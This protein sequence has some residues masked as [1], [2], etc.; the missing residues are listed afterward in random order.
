MQDQLRLFVAAQVPEEVK[1][2]LGQARHVYDLPGIK[3]VPDQNL[4]LTLYFLG[5]VPATEDSFIRQKL[6]EV[7]QRHQPFTLALER[8]EPGPKPKAPRLIWARFAQNDPFSKISKDLATVLSPVPPRQEKFIP[9]V[10]LC[11]FKKEGGLPQELPL[12][13]PDQEVLFPVQSLALWQSQL[14]SPHPIYT[15][16]EEFLLG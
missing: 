2:Y 9:H 7:A 15:V 10:T 14:A 13:I 4:H 16:V 1:S 3:A 11:R 8:L 12:V 5:N 6:A